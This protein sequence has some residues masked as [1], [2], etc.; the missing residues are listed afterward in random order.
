MP[1]SYNFCKR[2]TKTAQLTVQLD[3]LKNIFKK[4]IKQSFSI[5]ATVCDQGA[6]NVAAIKEL[7]LRTDIKRNFEK[8][9]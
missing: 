4:L 6:S 8:R 3:A 1:I 7:L 5:V 2:A 9:I